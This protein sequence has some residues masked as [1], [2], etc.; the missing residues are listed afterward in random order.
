MPTYDDSE[1]VTKQLETAPDFTTRQ[2]ARL[3]ELLEPIKIT[4]D[5]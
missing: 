1:W 5:K 2:E 3:A 4:R